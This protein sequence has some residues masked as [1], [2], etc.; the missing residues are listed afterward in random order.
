MIYCPNCGAIRKEQIHIERPDLRKQN[1]DLTPILPTCRICGAETEVR[2]TCTGGR[3][4]VLNGTCG[5]GKS[6]LAEGLAKKGWGVVDGDCAMQSAR[7]RR[8]GEKV[9]FRGAM[10]EIVREIDILS[11]YHTHMVLSHVILPEDMDRYGA[12]FRRR[13]LSVRW[14]LLRPSLQTAI[15][16]CRTR[17][18]HAS[19]T[20]EYW[21]RYFY[22][23]LTADGR[24]EILDT[25][26]MTAEDTLEYLLRD[27]I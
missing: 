25:T 7:Y 16:R 14:I 24:A 11:L 5:S 6:T 15:A 18:C 2:H 27:E 21:I 20:P 26:D 9:D 23:A 19:V 10:E 1:F 3:L 12:E 22:D 17:T 13:N 4:L 8:R